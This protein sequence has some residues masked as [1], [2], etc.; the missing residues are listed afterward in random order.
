MSFYDFKM[1]VFSRQVIPWTAMDCVW[2]RNPD[3]MPSSQRSNFKREKMQNRSKLLLLLSVIFWVKWVLV[4]IGSDFCLTLICHS[5]QQVLYTWLK[6]ECQMCNCIFCIS[7]G[8]DKF[9]NSLIG[10]SS[11]FILKRLKINLPS[12]NLRVV[13][14]HLHFS[15]LRR[16]RS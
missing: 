8:F 9:S 3:G 2:E 12:K 5:S 10:K 16:E 13:N 11:K 14:Q 4:W 1:V 6:M 15:Y 7:L